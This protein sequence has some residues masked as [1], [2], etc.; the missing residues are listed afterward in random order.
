MDGIDKYENQSLKS[1]FFKLTNPEYHYS[2]GEDR[3]QW[4][5]YRIPVLPAYT[6]LSYTV[7]GI[8]AGSEGGVNLRGNEIVGDTVVIHGMNEL[9]TIFGTQDLTLVINYLG[10]NS[11]EKFFP[12]FD[13]DSLRERSA[14][15]L[16]EADK[17]FEESSWFAFVMMAGAVF[18]SFL[19]DMLGDEEST[20]GLLI[21]KVREL[22]VFTNREVAALDDAKEARNII[23]AGRHDEPYVTREKAM[24]V[25][26]VLEQF[27]RSDWLEIKQKYAEQK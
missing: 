16:E 20:F 3:C 18:E 10:I 11:Y 26:L 27:L 9:A 8:N 21:N 17:T 6:I 13:D 19:V 23:H 4:A 5:T 22:S 25:R 1:A 14:Q 12:H 15:F 7:Q 24:N 2:D